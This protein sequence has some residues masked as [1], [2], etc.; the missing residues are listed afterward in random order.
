[1]FWAWTP[2]QVLFVTSEAGLEALA[3]FSSAP[4][5]SK[6]GLWGLVGHPRSQCAG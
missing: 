6:A 1:M 5:S 2:H 4:S 3:S